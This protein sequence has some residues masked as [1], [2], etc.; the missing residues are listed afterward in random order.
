MGLKDLH[1][2]KQTSEGTIN[3]NVQN[4]L[5]SDFESLIQR[6]IKLLFTKKGSNE[7]NPNVGTHLFD[8]ITKGIYSEEHTSEVYIIAQQAIKYVFHTIS[9]EQQNASGNDIILKDLILEEFYFDKIEQK[10]FM[11]IKIVT[12]YT[13]TNIGTYL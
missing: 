11:N 4:V 1:I 7:F 10:W 8:I 13:I 2:I 9:V 3:F 5:S 12:N 6:I